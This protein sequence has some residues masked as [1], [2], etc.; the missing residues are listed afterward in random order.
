MTSPGL[1]HAAHLLN[2][3][4]CVQDFE[5]VGALGKFCRPCI[6]LDQNL[7]YVASRI[8]RHRVVLSTIIFGVLHCDVC[9]RT[10]TYTCP[11]EYCA[12]CTRTAVRFLDTQDCAALCHFRETIITDPIVI[13]IQ[14]SRSSVFNS[15]S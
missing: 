8:F 12:I 11:A 10:L 7:A 1:S 9:H 6:S 15:I 5:T 3:A 14:R 13:A 2:A 4:H